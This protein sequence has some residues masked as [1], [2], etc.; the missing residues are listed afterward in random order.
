MPLDGAIATCSVL[1]LLLR[2]PFAEGQS[3]EATS[4]AFM[5]EQILSENGCGAFAGLI[6]STAAA[7][8]AF[9]AQIA[10][11]GGGKG[12]TIFCPDDEAVA[13]F[14]SGRFSNLSADSQAALLLYHGVA[15]LYSEE[16]LGAMFDTEVATLANGP[17]DYHIH[18]LGGTGMPL[19]LSSSPNEA[20]VTKMVVDNDRLVVF[21]INS[22]LVP[23][24]PTASASWNWDWEHVLLVVVCI[25]VALVAL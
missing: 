11:D 23:G 20:G 12:L 16:A 18:I 10:G 6:A 4:E 13:A 3:S 22:V 1:L 5:M 14:G 19:I 8:E 25:A 17:G 15:T 9:R 21:L 2:T 7:G 24:G